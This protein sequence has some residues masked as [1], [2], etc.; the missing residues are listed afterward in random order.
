M[1]QTPL[2][3]TF[4]S[5]AFHT[6]AQ[7]SKARR[8]GH[9][10]LEET[11]TDINILELK[12]RHPGEIYSRTFNKVEEGTNGADWEWWLTDQRRMLWLGIRV[13]AKILKTKSNSFEHLHYKSKKGIY[14]L[15]KLKSAAQKNNLLPIYCLYFQ[16]QSLSWPPFRQCRT[17]TNNIESY[18]CSLL[19]VD[20]VNF[21]QSNHEKCDFNSVMVAAVPWHCLVCC[22][23]YKQDNL[24]KRA[25]A[26]LRQNEML[27]GEVENSNIEFLRTDPPR[28]IND[29]IEEKET[30]EPP[31]GVRQILIVQEQST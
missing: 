20:H 4:R 7:I 1:S 13:Q 23:G 31:V 8:I 30:E 28:Y 21:L 29:I 15:D 9:Q 25:L 10:L 22:H 3:E 26:F 16:N 12:D 2:C 14:Q 17:F 19:G 6:F 27:S 11:I 5:L 24:P 18:G